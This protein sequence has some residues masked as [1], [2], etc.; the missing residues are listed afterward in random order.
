MDRQSMVELSQASWF[1]LGHKEKVSWHKLIPVRFIQQC[2]QGGAG[3]S[4]VQG[5]SSEPHVRDVAASP[6][7]LAPAGT[8][9]G[10]LRPG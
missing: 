5:S 3:T 6:P 2:F 7:W 10:I 4:R 1:R 8:E 9:C